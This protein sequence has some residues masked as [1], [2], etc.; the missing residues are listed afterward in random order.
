M[1][2]S[3]I[4]HVSAVLAERGRLSER[5]HLAGRSGADLRSPLLTQTPLPPNHSALTSVAR[6][7]MERIRFPPAEEFSGALTVARGVI[8][9][10]FS[11]Y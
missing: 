2:I 3:L 5:E 10:K 4:S 11:K 1:A 9:A 7:H 6:E 8:F